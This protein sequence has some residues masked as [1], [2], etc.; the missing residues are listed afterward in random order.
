M[1]PLNIQQRLFIQNIGI[2]VLMVLLMGSLYEQARD[3]LLALLPL[4]VLTV[5]GIILLPLI[6]GHSIAEPFRSLMRSLDLDGDK[7]LLTVAKFTTSGPEAGRLA[8]G[9]SKMLGRQREFLGVLSHD[10]YETE[11][12]VKQ[13]G[14][15]I[16]ELDAHIHVQQRELEQ[17]AAALTE[18]SSSIEEVARNAAQAEHMAE[19]AEQASH[20][21]R[22]LVSRY[23]GETERLA[24][25]LEASV[26]DVQALERDSDDIGMVLQVISDIANQTNLL[27]LNAAIEAAR[28]GEHGRGFAVVADEVRTL[29]T[30]TQAST[31]QVE[32]IVA[33]F[34]QR[35]KQV[36]AAIVACHTQMGTCVDLGH[37][38]DACLASIDRA[39]GEIS[40]ANIQNAS[41]VEQQNITAAQLSRSLATLSASNER[42]TLAVD[43][44]AGYGH[45]L[46]Q[47]TE[48][49][50][51]LLRRYKLGSEEAFD[52]E[53]VKVAH[54]TWKRRLRDFLDGKAALSESQ[55]VSHHHCLLGSWYYGP[56]MA[57]YG[58]I[59]EFRD[60]EQ[61]HTELHYIIQQILHLKQAGQ[62]DEAQRLFQRV[63]PLSLQ[64]VNL[65]DRL[66]QSINRMGA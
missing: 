12:E 7:G 36:A 57:Q 49:Q 44:V 40:Q 45:E 19:A 18:M 3:H 42:F 30:R 2:I 62:M 4:V 8:A 9:L 43:Q 26:R 54:L 6:I 60:L 37:Q 50:T 38:A 17:Q 16:D 25:Q 32:E 66:E 46:V 52:F 5:G 14:S 34:Q 51:A 22:G 15:V 31:Q 48:R 29:A 28:A 53:A 63:E 41:A 59:P 56:G 61:P 35:S 21:G 33:R 39:V 1:N 24:Q 23:I 47:A 20:A 55:A 65:L 10:S 13:L 58:Q 64:L 27:A 11:A